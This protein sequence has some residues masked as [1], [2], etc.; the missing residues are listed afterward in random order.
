MM[1]RRR[2]L[3][4]ACLALAACATRGPVTPEPNGVNGWHG[5]T[6]PG[7]RSTDYRIE[8]KEGRRTVRADA[9]RSA[10]LWRKPVALHADQLGEIQ[11]SWWVEALIPQ[12]SLAEAERSDAPARIVLTFG[13]DNSRLSLR[14]RLMYDLAASLS[15]E[16]PPY[17]T[18]MYVWETSAPVDSV[19]HSQRSDRIRKIVVESGP[20]E[21]RRWR[22][23][24]RDVAAD[25][26]RAF[27]EEPG[28]LTGVALMT[29]ADNT[30]SRALAWYGEVRLDGVPG[31]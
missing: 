13:G 19:I 17:A 30:Q 14:N 9:D 5:F 25:Y 31:W 7:K 1:I 27:G 2:C 29:D 21:L 23:Y 20:G 8:T 28:P 24:R 12:A 10:S 26:R 11:F 22:H 4:I 16:E 18:L 6:L 15:G 3:A